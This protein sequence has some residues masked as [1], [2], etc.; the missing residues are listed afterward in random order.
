MVC[1]NRI[2]RADGPL[3][4][5]MVAECHDGAIADDSNPA[6]LEAR[7]LSMAAVAGAVHAVVAC[8][9]VP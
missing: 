6:A 5:F 2:S 9:T 7:R 8:E 3:L 4:Q 1:C